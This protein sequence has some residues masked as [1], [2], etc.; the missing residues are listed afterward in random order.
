VIRPHPR[1][2]F[3]A[4]DPGRRHAEAIV[5][6]SARRLSRVGSP[7]SPPAKIVRRTPGDG[8]IVGTELLRKL[9]E[10]LGDKGQGRDRKIDPPWA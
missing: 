5:R 7:V 3:A 9:R 8:E 10:R 2:L 6:R 4:G 1:R